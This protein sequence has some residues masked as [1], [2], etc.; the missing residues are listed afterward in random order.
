MS[1]QPSAKSYAGTRLVYHHFGHLHPEGK[2]FSPP[3]PRRHSKQLVFGLKCSPTQDAKRK[4]EIQTYFAFYWARSEVRDG[5]QADA[6]GFSDVAIVTRN[7]NLSSQPHKPPNNLRSI[8]PKQSRASSAGTV[9]ESM[10]GPQ[11]SLPR[12][13]SDKP[14]KA[15]LAPSYVWSTKVDPQPKLTPQVVDHGTNSDARTISSARYDL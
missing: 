11:Q 10:N 4:R 3:G 9:F 7:D 2:F 12:R 13:I 14:S 5:T 15:S 6:G 1:S 8:S